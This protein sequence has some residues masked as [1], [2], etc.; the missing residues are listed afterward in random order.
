MYYVHILQYGARALPPVKTFY[1]T[2]AAQLTLLSRVTLFGPFIQ[3]DPRA[4]VSR[5]STQDRSLQ[6]TE[7]YF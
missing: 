2:S 1:T 6:L 7:T 5:R 4:V 3:Q